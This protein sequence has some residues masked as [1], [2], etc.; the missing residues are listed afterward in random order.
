MRPYKTDTRFTCVLDR[1]RQLFI[2]ITINEAI[3]IFSSGVESNI[4]LNVD[5]KKTVLCV[6]TIHSTYFSRECELTF[7]QR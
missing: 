1:P 7:I 2:I 3:G 5:K 4:R 6:R